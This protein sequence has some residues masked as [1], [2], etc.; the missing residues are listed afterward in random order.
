MPSS[1]HNILRDLPQTELKWIGSIG[2]AGYSPE[3]KQNW[4]QHELTMNAKV[5]FD[6]YAAPKLDFILSNIQIPQTEVPLVV[7]DKRIIHRT[8][9]RIDELDTK[10]IAISAASRF[11]NTWNSLTYPFTSG[12]YKA[13]LESL[14]RYFH[15]KIDK[16]KSTTIWVEW[17]NNLGTDTRLYT[18]EYDEKTQSLKIACGYGMVA[19]DVTVK[20]VKP[21]EVVS[22]V[23]LWSI[24]MSLVE[25]YNPF[26]D[27][28]LFMSRDEVTQFT[29]PQVYSSRMEMYEGMHHKR[30]IMN[31]TTD[32]LVVS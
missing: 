12:A 2:S 32:D 1:I 29:D 19:R 27:K 17:S 20:E 6:Q 8:H 26:M 16:E 5:K 21:T 24:H 31:S 4:I 3:R 11:Y 18:Y 14:R 9:K 30:E 15:F 13:K 22:A 23:E 28:F 7:G 25:S 10:Q